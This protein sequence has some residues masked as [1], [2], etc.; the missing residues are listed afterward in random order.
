MS[1]AAVG[2]AH[3]HTTT[4]LSGGSA[5]EG[6]QKAPSPHSSQ[7]R[8][9]G[10]PAVGRRPA[11]AIHWNGV[12]MFPCVSEPTALVTSDASGAWGCGAF[13]LEW[14]PAA[15]HY[16]ISFKELFVGVAAAGRLWRGARVR[17][18]CD[19]QA[20]VYAVTRRSCRDTGMMHLVR[21]LFFLEGWYDFELVAAH[22]PGRENM[23]A[24]DLSRNRLSAFLSKVQ[25]PDPQPTALPL[26]LAEM[27]LDPTGWTSP[28]WTRRFCA[29][30]SRLHVQNLSVRS[31]PISYMFGVSAPFP[32]SE[33]LLCYFVTSLVR[34]GVA[35]S[36]V[37]T[38]L[39]AVR[40]AQIMRGHPG[41]QLSLKRSKTPNL[42]TSEH[43]TETASMPT[44]S[45][46]C[47]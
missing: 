36:T 31:E 26:E 10:G 33:A 5:Q 20:A 25:S 11:S 7:P 39:A 22:L 35:P 24:D 12:A 42:N 16:H 4:C 27:L 23:L 17:W 28:R 46:S 41:P 43:D 30:A 2:I 34:E 18:L 19:K 6:V 1:A 38:Y 13:Q 9:P 40:H 47:R 37:R 32:V 44:L 14:P 29:I 8:V 15:Q 21:C 3:R 45:L